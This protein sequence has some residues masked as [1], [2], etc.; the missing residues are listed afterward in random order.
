MA[1]G[2]SREQA[3]TVAGRTRRT[4]DRWIFEDEAF[5]Q[6]L[7][8]VSD[9]AIG[10]ASRR[11]AFTL[12]LAIDTIDSLMRSETAPAHIRLR[13]AGLAIDAALKLSEYADLVAR[14]E[15]LEGML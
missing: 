15:R 4:L 8:D 6:A 12:G 1:A 5:G 11:L 10:E 13:A 7:A 9:Q 2:A 3:A 14:V